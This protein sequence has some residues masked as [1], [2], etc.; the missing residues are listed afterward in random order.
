[1]DQ[2]LYLFAFFFF[3]VYGV[4]QSHGLSKIYCLSGTTF[5]SS[6]VAQL[7]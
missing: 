4:M 3:I 7:V 5:G 2:D 1:M 6:P